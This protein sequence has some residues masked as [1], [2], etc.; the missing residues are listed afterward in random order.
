M[1]LPSPEEKR[2]FSRRAVVTLLIAAAVVVIVVVAFVR[3][4]PDGD[5]ELRAYQAAQP[6]PS[7]PDAPAECR[8]TQEFTISDI[9]LTNARN[10]D[11]SAVLTDADG[12]EWETTYSSRGP[13][14]NQLDE[15]DRVTA[16]LWRGRV[17]EIA[18]HG[19][20]Q[21][22]NDAPVDLREGRFALAL[23]VVPPGLLVMAACVWRLVRR[24]LPAPTRGMA[25][26]LGLAGALFPVGIFARL[27][28]GDRSDSPWAV[29]ALWAVLAALAAVTAGLCATYTK[30]T[31]DAE[32]GRTD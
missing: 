16:T 15:G 7:A 11:N 10:A 21:N 25:A 12:T 23:A 22:T 8:W 28:V 9:Y 6:C 32:A 29:V 26:T 20:S 14:L 18:A 19:R 4:L 5:R 1:N 13:V 31:P 3:A 24:D 2:R 17:I 30:K 27:M